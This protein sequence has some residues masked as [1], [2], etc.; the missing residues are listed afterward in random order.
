LA[1]ATAH[2]GIAL[3]IISQ[4]ALVAV[5]QLRIP[6]PALT[7]EKLVH[8]L[9][10]LANQGLMVTVILEDLEE[11]VPDHTMVVVAVVVAQVPL[12]EA[13]LVAIVV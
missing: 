5:D 13:L 11:L 3:E 9:R 6:V 4:E 8:N 10:N 2:N 1:V 7:Q 12:V